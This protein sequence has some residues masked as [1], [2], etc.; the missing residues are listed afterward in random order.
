MF[1]SLIQQMS[2]NQKSGQ[3]TFHRRFAYGSL[4]ISPYVPAGMLFTKRN[5]N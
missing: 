1:V 5:K 4:F 3:K 2:I